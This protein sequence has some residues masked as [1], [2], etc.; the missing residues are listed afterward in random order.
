M[1]AYDTGAADMPRTVGS[2]VS[3]IPFR[4]TIERACIQ[5]Q[6]FAVKNVCVCIFI[7]FNF[8]TKGKTVLPLLNYQGPWLHLHRQFRNSI[9]VLRTSHKLA[10]KG[11]KIE[12]AGNINNL[13]SAY[14]CS[15][16]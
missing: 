1:A 2:F 14:V 16:K 9:S 5:V 7:K 12:T 6:R 15:A 8:V 11:L 4:F 3:E 13:A 10:A